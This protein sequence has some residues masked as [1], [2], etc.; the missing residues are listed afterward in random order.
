VRF[1]TEAEQLVG[2]GR[3]EELHAKERIAEHLKQLGSPF[4][5]RVGKRP[6][7]S[8]RLEVRKR[9][10]R[11]RRAGS[12]VAG[13]VFLRIGAAGTVL[14]TEEARGLEPLGDQGDPEGARDAAARIR[15]AQQTR[16]A[17]EVVLQLEGFD[18]PL[19]R[20]LV[21]H[22]PSFRRG[23][24]SRGV[25]LG[26][27]RERPAPR[28]TRIRGRRGCRG[29]GSG[30]SGGRRRRWRWCRGG[31]R[32]RRGSSGRVVGGRVL[33]LRLRAPTHGE[34]NGKTRGGKFHGGL[35]RSSHARFVSPPFGRRRTGSVGSR[36][37]YHRSRWFPKD[38]SFVARSPTPPFP[39]ATTPHPRAPGD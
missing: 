16:G 22:G 39:Q 8:K 5:V 13:V 37:F 15:D 14:R 34:Q 19:V 35:H 36:G 25:A 24:G 2:L 26:P 1:T 10:D 21:G 9:S 7:R 30:R 33:T 6:E 29:G 4:A 31:R 18:A 38:S 27:G 17:V 32:R 3:R 11:E 20:V 12:E 28:S 23:G